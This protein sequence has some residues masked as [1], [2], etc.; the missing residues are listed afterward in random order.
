MAGSPMLARPAS[1][2]GL[3]LQGAR[4]CCRVARWMR[5]CDHDGG[6]SRPAVVGAQLARFLALE[7]GLGAAAM[8]YRRL[9]AFAFG[10][11]ATA[12]ASQMPTEQLA[13]ASSAIDRAEQAGASEYAA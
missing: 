11:L 13:V 7:R 12:C 9:I 10:A 1:R 8:S 6:P 3:F 2:R 5:G 4:K